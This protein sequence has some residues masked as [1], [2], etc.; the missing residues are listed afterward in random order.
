M[1]TWTD[2]RDAVL[3]LPA[4]G[5][6]SQH[7]STNLRR[8]WTRPHKSVAVQLQ[9]LPKPTYLAACS[10]KAQPSTRHSASH[11]FMRSTLQAMLFLRT[12]NRATEATPYLFLFKPYIFLSNSHRLSFAFSKAS[13]NCLVFLFKNGRNCRPAL[14]SSVCCHP[15]I[16]DYN[17]QLAALGL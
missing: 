15:W 3:S 17:T 7:S 14:H 12:L 10:E 5:H 4:H 11:F 16:G 1:K 2:L 9:G 6:C 13:C 8:I